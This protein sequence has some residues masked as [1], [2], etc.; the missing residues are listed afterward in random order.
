MPIRYSKDVLNFIKSISL[1]RC[2]SEILVLINEKYPELEMTRSKLKSLMSNHKICSGYTLKGTS[3]YSKEQIDFLK[4]YIPGRPDNDTCEEFYK[5]FG[6]KLTRKNLGNIKIKNNIKNGLVGGQ[7]V[8]GQ[9]PHNKGKKWSE[10]MSEEGQ[11]NSLKTAYK[12]GNIPANR[13]EIGTERITKDGYIQVKIQD[14]KGN[15]NWIEKHRLVY[16]SAFG[17]VPKGQKIIFLDGDKT[18]CSL[19]N[20]QVVSDYENLVLNQNGMYFKNKELTET[21]VLVAK[22]ICKE[23]K[24]KRQMKNGKKTATVLEL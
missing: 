24:L 15:R 16:E 7:F 21:S 17:K 1:G 8:K 10:F 18:N 2:S 14:G 5:R 19:D 13:S 3:K 6:I 9:V 23:N 22:I 4:K 20:L 12:K 11:R